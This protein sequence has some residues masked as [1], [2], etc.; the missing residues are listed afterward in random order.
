VIEI[1]GWGRYPRHRTRILAPSDPHTAQNL[2]TGPTGLVS[3]GNGRAYGDAAIGQA[4]TAFTVGLNR[5]RS[6][7]PET[8]RLTVEAGVLLSEIL[9]SFV[10]RGF[11]RPSC[12][13]QSSSR[14]A[15]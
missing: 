14:S 1:S 8:G 12:P 6:F 10:P 5:M 13:G 15:A 11:F 7:D 9:E 4:V 2:L 3:R